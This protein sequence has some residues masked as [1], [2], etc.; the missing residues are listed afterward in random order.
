MVL[1]YHSNPKIRPLLRRF[2]SSSFTWI[3]NL[4]FGHNLKYYNGPAVHKKDIISR[5]TISSNGFAYQAEI[6]TRLL[7][8]GCSYVEVG[9]KTRSREHGH[10][11]ALYPKSI[12][13]VFKTIAKIYYEIVVKNKSVI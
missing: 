13:N 5:I 7:K 9:M 11:K 6:L 2:L 8:E 4:L 1:P 12:L 3:L 10:S